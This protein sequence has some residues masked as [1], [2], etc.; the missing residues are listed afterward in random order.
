MML[1]LLFVRHV[2]AIMIGMA[3]SSL[4][5]GAAQADAIPYPN[6]WFQNAIT[7]TIRAADTGPVAGYY[8][9]QS[10]AGFIEDVGLYDVT[11][12]QQVGGMGLANH[13][14][15]TGTMF[16]FG[17]VAGGDQLAVFIRIE[18]DYT[19]P[20][21]LNETGLTLWSIPALN[22][23]NAN[24]AYAATFSGNGQIPGGV[25]IGF[26]D[27]LANNHPDWNYMDEQIVLTNVIASGSYGE[28]FTA[29]AEPE[30][31]SI[32]LSGLVGLA[33]VWQRRRK[34]Q[35]V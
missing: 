16:D 6:P 12:G 11:S 7:F 35:A 32:A 17:P 18:D 15:P 30:A 27:L 9:A 10:Q 28:V 4:I 8:Y 29:V 31:G 13:G 24:H 3:V 34:M 21:D 22:P 1:R 33:V 19:P 5:S 23:D 14:T 20:P 25:Y 26:E 2:Q